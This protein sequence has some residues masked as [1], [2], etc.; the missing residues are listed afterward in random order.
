M[1]SP[2]K[3]LAAATATVILAAGLGIGC[4]DSRSADKSVRAKL[5]AAFAETAKGEEAR[6]AAIQLQEEAV[7]IDQASPEGKAQAREALAR[8]FEE[9][10]GHLSSEVTDNQRRMARLIYEIGELGN[11]IQAGNTKAASYRLAEPS[12][13][14][15]IIAVRIAEAQGGADK[16]IWFPAENAHIATLAASKQLISQLQ[17]EIAKRQQQIK[18]LSEQRAGVL[19]QAEQLRSKSEQLRGRQA[20]DAFRQASTARKQAAD[21]ATQIAV[22][23][24]E[25]TPL[26]RDLAVAQ[27][28]A[29]AAQEAIGVY[30]K[31]LAAIEQGWKQIQQQVEQQAAISASIVG[32]GAAQTQPNVEDGPQASAAVARTMS[33]K[34]ARL[35]AMA[36]ENRALFAEAEQKLQNAVKHYEDAAASAEQLA[37]DVR[38]QS[39]DLDRSS[40][41]KI[42]YDMLLNVIHP[43]VYR[44]G[45][46][47]ANQSLAMLHASR[48]ISLSDRQRLR[49]ALEPVLSA[50]GLEI[51]KP[52]A[53]VQ[54]EQELKASAEEAAAK[55]QAAEELYTTVTSEAPSDPL[56][57]AGHVGRIFSLYGQLLIARATGNAAQEK[58]MLARAVEAR[59]AAE[60]NKAMLPALPVE[61]VVMPPTTAPTAAPATKPVAPA[62]AAPAGPTARAK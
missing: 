32:A 59:N 30:Q 8:S 18:Q 5:D 34:A 9:S 36:E 6:P 15:Q 35:S 48:L 51:P 54:V 56:K 39:A 31:Q 42:A 20:V 33:E 45:A 37:R 62:P 25:I 4:D 55:F 19:Q 57:Q 43:S 28:Q 3:Q 49:T 29:D 53:D 7:A 61:L 22:I 17:G 41:T 26:Q 44:L 14:R 21:L 50:A 46:A 27:V 12:D 16:P 52:L 11:Q 2:V 10:A 40:P 24:A 13:E 23:E 58:E 38:Q 47:N 1:Y 60:E